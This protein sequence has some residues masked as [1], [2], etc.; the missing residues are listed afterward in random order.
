[1]SFFRAKNSGAAVTPSYTGLQL[2]TSTNTLPVP[3]VWGATK[4]AANVI[5]YGAFQTI[6]LYVKN[7]G[8]G[9][10]GNQTVTGY[11]YSASLVL[12]LSEGPIAGI[13]VIWK[14][15]STASLSS[16]GFSLFAGT[17]PQ[18]AWGYLSASFSSQALGYGG[19]AYVCAA[20]YALGS[21]AN[22]GNHNFEVL[23][24][25]Y[26]TGINAVDADP[27]LVISDFLTNP[28]YGVGFS[29]A[30]ISAA[31]LFG[32]S[33]DAS[34]QTWC[35]AMG[36]AFSP[37]LT[38][39]E[40]ASSI[41]TRW[42]QLI[43]CAAVW[44]GGQLKFIPYGDASFTGFGF[45]FAP[46][47]TP[48]YNLAD[49]DFVDGGD[50]VDPVLVSRVDPFSLPTIQRIEV[51]DRDNSYA[52]TPVEARDQSQI[53]LYGPR[54][55]STIQAHEITEIASG[56]AGVV[57]QMILQ[58]TLYVRAS[59]TFKLSWEYCLLDPMDIVT[60]TDANLGLADF[61]VRIVA[62]EEDDQGVLTIT[63]EEFTAGL[64][65]AALYPTSGSSSTIPNQA[66]AADPINTPLIV[67]PPPALTA[68]VAQ[69]WVGASGGLAGVAD[70]NWGGAYVWLSLDN[71]TYSQI[72]TIKQ[73]LRQGFLTA[74]L[75]LASGFDVAHTLSVNL[76]ESGGALTGSTDVGAQQGLTLALVDAELL[77]YSTATLT[78]ASA[79]NLTRL[80]R[81]LDGALPAAHASGAPFARLDGAVVAY[82]L[83]ANAVGET[84]YFKFQSFNVFGAGVQSLA[85][86]AAYPY[87]PS[88]VGSLGPVASSL[89]AG[90]ALDYD[91]ISHV[92]SETDDFGNLTAP[93]VTVID[94]GSLAS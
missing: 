92:V 53:D 67:E 49:N 56:L 40:Q 18:S 28:Q 76:M 84:L 85:A 15:Q 90:T 9:G 59:F 57:A 68:N 66:A 48:I 63:A 82:N 39:Q 24:V 25:L 43:N 10:H 33:G 16:L 47:L 13:G 75:A 69:V 60:L 52:A 35:R 80:A 36:L 2:Q 79:Y 83:P 37:A 44:S 64:G 32:A 93:Y 31:T 55:G 81:G 74:S 89:A 61:P 3:I 72:A 58:R 26:A 71:V 34:V 19:T 73:P 7:S 88:G 94:L 5:W 45:A 50:N 91:L 30:S 14:D 87:V 51:L 29:G 46:N 17:T 86:C 78:G 38:D 77:A 21:S 41:L 23:G 4:I 12:A 54:V 1:M 70:P 27:A 65:V 22:I 62:I 8:K 6:P 11:N 20:N 42:L